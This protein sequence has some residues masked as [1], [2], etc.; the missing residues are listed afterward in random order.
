[1]K[2]KYYKKLVYIKFYIMSSLEG[3]MKT[4][5][6]DASIRPEILVTVD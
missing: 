5:Y 3:K 4:K 1:L 2:T 6:F